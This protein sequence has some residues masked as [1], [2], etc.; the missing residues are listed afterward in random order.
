[1][2]VGLLAAGGAVLAQPAETPKAEQPVYSVVEPKA[3]PK[4]KPATRKRAA[5]ANVKALA[6]TK[7]RPSVVARADEA[8]KP[9]GRCVVKPVMSD[10]DLVNCGATP[11][12]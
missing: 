1:M 6:K 5:K 4:A 7:A 11:H 2:L 12:H 9:N 3:P 8:L 10:Q